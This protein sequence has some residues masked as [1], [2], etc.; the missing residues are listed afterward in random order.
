MS[1]NRLGVGGWVDPR[2]PNRDADGRVVCRR[3]SAVIPKGRRRTFCSA[4][5]VHEWRLRTDAGYLR[6]KTFERDHG[7]CALCG[8][9]SVAERRVKKARG[10]GRCWQADHI[11]P[12]V[13][14]GGQCGLDNIRTLCHVCHLAMT[15][16]LAKRRAEKRAAAHRSMSL[17]GEQ[18]NA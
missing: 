4:E 11:V 5:C 8:V 9:D 1:T 17:F 16:E 18:S 10:T 7:I 15:A 6:L 12:V 13:E 3:C 14:G 2:Y